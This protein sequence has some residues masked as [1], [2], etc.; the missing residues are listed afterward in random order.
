M[1]VLQITLSIV[2]QLSLLGCQLAFPN[3]NKVKVEIFSETVPSENF[4]L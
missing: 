2:L 4:G 1:P 3:A